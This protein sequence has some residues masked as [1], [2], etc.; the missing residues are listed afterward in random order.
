MIVPNG[1]L[2]H[3]DEAIIE[4]NQDLFLQSLHTNN[5]VEELESSKKKFNFKWIES[6][7]SIRNRKRKAYWIHCIVNKKEHEEMSKRT[8]IEKEEK[9][10]YKFNEEVR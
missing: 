2:E 6:T 8:T 7:R 3:L 4:I 9:T 10:S 5:L 1:N